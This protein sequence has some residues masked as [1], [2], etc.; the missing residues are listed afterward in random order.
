[1][2]EISIDEQK[3]NK[4]IL[5]GNPAGSFIATNSFNLLKCLNGAT[6][7]KT[8]RIL[9]RERERK[10]NKTKQ[11]NKNLFTKCTKM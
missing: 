5:T 10:E 11:N 6:T 8:F 4:P 9:Q 3:Q 1:M 2:G 7:S